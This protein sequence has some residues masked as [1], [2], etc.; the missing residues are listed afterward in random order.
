MIKQMA[1]YTIPPQTDG[2]DFW[3]YHTQE[4]APAVVQ[5][6]GDNL[7]QYTINRVIDIAKGAHNF[8]G[9]VETWWQDPAAMQNGFQ[10]LEDTL[11]PGGKSIV[12]DYFGRLAGPFVA[13]EVEE[14]VAKKPTPAIPHRPA[15]YMGFYSLPPGTDADRFWAYHTREHAVHS[16]DSFGNYLKYYVINRVSRV[17]DGDPICFGIVELWFEGRQQLTKGF[18]DHKHMMLANGRNVSED[19]DVRVADAFGYLVEEFNAKA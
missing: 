13:F 10:V 11:L 3:R 1:L 12:Q 4:H 18:E 8:F 2:D 9:V 16:V 17:V 14:Y 7:V 15:K 6:C 19:F 5:A